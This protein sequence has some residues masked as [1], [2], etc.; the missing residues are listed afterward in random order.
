MAAYSQYI[1]DARRIRS[2]FVRLPLATRGLSLVIVLFY[3]AN[4]YWGATL[5]FWGALIPE[6]IGIKSLYRLNTFPLIHKSLFHLLLNLFTLIPLLERF[7]AEHGTITTFILFTGPFG[8]IPGLIYTFLERFLFHLNTGVVG[9][10]IWVFLLLANESIKLYKAN[11]EFVLGGF[12]IPTWVTPIFGILLVWFLVPGTSLLGH[13]CG[14][15]VGYLWGV[16]W[17][18]FLAPHD[19]IL[20]WVEGKL[21]LLGRLPHYVSVD[22]KTYGRYGVLPSTRSAGS[23]SVLGT[24]EDGRAAAAGPIG[25]TQ[26]LGP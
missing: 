14:A 20:R 4:L 3:L 25:S 5:H 6:Q 19:K 22:Q 18:R 21:N 9:S 16:G 13:L 8:L 17:I 23:T 1:P 26:R 10:S 24:M 12:G 11:P 2:F 15:A 7:E